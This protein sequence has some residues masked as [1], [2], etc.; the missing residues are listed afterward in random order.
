MTE[1]TEDQLD[2]DGYRYLRGILR[3]TMAD[4]D[5]WDGEDSESYILGQY[6]KWLAAGQPRDEDGYP[7]RGER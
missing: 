2:A 4:P 6:I 7:D 5:L 1:P 3:D